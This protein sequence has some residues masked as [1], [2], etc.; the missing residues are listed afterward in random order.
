MDAKKVADCLQFRTPA[1]W[2]GEKWREGLFVGNGKLGANVYGG[3][4]DEE[5]LLNHGDLFW[6][7]RPSVVPDISTKLKDIRK[8]IDDGN[9]FEAQQVAPK[10]LLTKNFRPQAEYPLPL[11]VLRV[12]MNNSEA[13][14]DYSR[15]LNMA[16]G[17]ATV[18]YTCGN[19]R[20]ERNLFASRD[21]NMVVYQITKV[22]SET[23]N[24]EIDYELIHR[25]NSRTP[26]G[27]SIMP[28]VVE[29]QYDKTFMR[30]A[31]R[32]E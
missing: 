2:W 22:G 15:Q 27:V 6:Q 10:A 11:C 24:F 4:I 14:C 29:T 31:G 1:S 23:L 25:I 32:N 30:F 13:V 21:K 16:T 17:E 7:G 18:S 20:V 8:L 9:F 12:K 28:D 19:T 26:D 5:I 3:A